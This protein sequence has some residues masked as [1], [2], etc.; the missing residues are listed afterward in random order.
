MRDTILSK[1]IILTKTHRAA[2]GIMAKGSI[3]ARVLHL[4]RF[5][6]LLPN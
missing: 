3:V 6:F 1:T 4:R 2:V 5:I